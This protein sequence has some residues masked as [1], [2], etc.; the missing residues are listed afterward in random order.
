[1]K[2]LEAQRPGQCEGAEEI[3]T[4]MSEK[5]QEPQFDT[6]KVK[7]KWKLVTL[8]NFLL[9]AYREELCGSPD[10]NWLSLST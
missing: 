1:M 8:K 2:C 7:S 5:H 3:K 4:V 6:V 9:I 10:H